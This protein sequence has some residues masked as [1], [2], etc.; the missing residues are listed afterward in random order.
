MKTVYNF[1]IGEI[2]KNSENSNVTDILKKTLAYSVNINHYKKDF[3][4]DVKLVYIYNYLNDNIIKYNETHTDFIIARDEK[5]F[6]KGP[7]F[8]AWEMIDFGEPDLESEILGKISNDLIEL[9]GNV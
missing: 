7:E 2:K 5:K 4:N 1:L 6:Q 8:M 3:K 9:R